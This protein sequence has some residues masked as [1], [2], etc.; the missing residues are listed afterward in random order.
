MKKEQ[1][2]LPSNRSFGILF[3]LV[4][5][6]IGIYPLLKDGDLRIWSLII[7]TIFLILGLLNS[8]I[9][10]PLNKIWM[11]FGYLLGAIIAPIVMALIFF[12]VVTPTGIF[13]KIAGKDLLNLK[14]KDKKTYWIKKEKLKSSMR[15]QF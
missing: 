6:I 14:K 10:Y 2:K 9:L 7:S 13:M 4:F 15:N 1:N 3:F 5:L 11:K 12:G 8:S